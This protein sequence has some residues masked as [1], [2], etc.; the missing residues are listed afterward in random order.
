MFNGYVVDFF[1]NI[2]SFLES[3]SLNLSFSANNGTP[4]Y[5]LTTTKKTG[6]FV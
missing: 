5:V 1:E 3:F 4:Y 6:L 2:P